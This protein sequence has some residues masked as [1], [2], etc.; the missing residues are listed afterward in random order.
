MFWTYLIWGSPYM[1]T[2]LIYLIL[3]TAIYSIIIAILQMKK[4]KFRER[5]SAQVI[6]PANSGVSIWKDIQ[7][8][9]PKG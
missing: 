7:P 9:L 8:G 2:A 3:T 1:L 6:K 4:L 5:N